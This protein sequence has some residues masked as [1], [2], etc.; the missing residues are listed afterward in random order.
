M[1]KWVGPNT[2]NPDCPATLH[3][4]KI[5]I[6]DILFLIIL[7]FTIR[8]Q[9]TSKLRIWDFVSYYERKWKE[10]LV[11]MI[12]KLGMMNTDRPHTQLWS[13]EV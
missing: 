3:G 4:T 1:E 6:T 7:Q 9:I 8:R 11:E 2:D 12:R 13:V 10:E 5:W